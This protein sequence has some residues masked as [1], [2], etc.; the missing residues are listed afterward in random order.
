MRAHALEGAELERAQTALAEA[1][2][3][4]QAYVSRRTRPIPAVRFDPID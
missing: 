3:H 1:Y 2:P 4:S